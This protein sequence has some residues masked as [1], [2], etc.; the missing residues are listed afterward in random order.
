MPQDAQY[1]VSYN[2][3]NITADISA[4]VTSLSYTDKTEGES[5][6]LELV[7]EDSTGIWKNEWYPEKGATITA[8]I[9]M[10]QNTL[11]CGTFTIDETSGSGGRDDG[12]TFTIKAISNGIS[13]RLRTIRGYAHENKTLAQVANT[14]ASE[15][16]YTV[17]GDIP[18][19]TLQRCTQYRETDLAFLHRISVQYGA[20]F[21]IKGTQLVFTSIYSIQGR[22]AVATID[23]T[24]LISY[25]ITDKTANTY[26]QARSQYFHPRQKRVISSTSTNTDTGFHRS[27][28]FLEIRTRNESDQQAQLKAQTALYNSNNRQQEG[29]IT[30]EG[31]VLAM[32]G[33]NVTLTSLGNYSGTFQISQSKHDVSRDGG[34]TT[35]LDIKRLGVVSAEQMKQQQQ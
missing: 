22:A 31:N 2:G 17:V 33:N 4:Y 26:L 30:I 16:G 27:S 8:Q 11:D 10:G 25:N 19:I 15:Y 12:D 35:T 14:I 28:N 34:Y 23:R 18:S 13:D 20:L 24:D 9:V 5:D 1:I 3:V 29:A 32:A 6:E 7:L 21:S